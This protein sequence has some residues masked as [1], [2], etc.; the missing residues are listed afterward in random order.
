M[1]RES[2]VAPLKERLTD[3]SSRKLRV[4]SQIFRGT[5]KPSDS[6]MWLRRAWFTSS[7]KPLMSNSKM[8]YLSLWACASSTSRRSVRAASRWEEAFRPPN[9]VVEISSRVDLVM[10]SFGDDFSRNFQ[11]HSSNAMGR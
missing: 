11:R 9:W 8:Q 2:L 10:Q 1:L 7:K 3:R 4:Q 5:R 6:K